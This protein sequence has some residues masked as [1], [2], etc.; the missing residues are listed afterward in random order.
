LGAPLGS[1]DPQTI[2]RDGQ[3]V[4]TGRS[5]YRL[6]AYSPNGAPTTNPAQTALCAYSTSRES[7]AGWLPPWIE[8]DPCRIVWAAAELVGRG[9]SKSK[10]P[11]GKGKHS[12]ARS[13]GGVSR[14]RT[15]VTVYRKKNKEDPIVDGR[16]DTTPPKIVREH[17]NKRTRAGARSR[18]WNGNASQSD[19]GEQRLVGRP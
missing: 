4:R 14:T 6:D 5:M 2:D 11:K 9:R 7:T 12:R 16:K 13:G 10:S 17:S 8:A 18:R 19:Q 3:P 1:I 15:L